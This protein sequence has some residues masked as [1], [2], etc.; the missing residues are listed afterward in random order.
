MEQYIKEILANDI[1]IEMKIALVEEELISGRPKK[2]SDS[3]NVVLLA[4]RLVKFGSSGES[5]LGWSIIKLFKQQHKE[6]LKAVLTIDVL[7]AI[8]Q[9]PSSLNDPGIAR[10]LE[11]LDVFLE[12]SPMANAEM[13]IEKSLVIYL[14][15]YNITKSDL[16]ST[17]DFY[18]KYPRCAPSGFSV[19]PFSEVLVKALAAFP[20]PQKSSLIADYSDE[21]K[22]FIEK[23]GNCLCQGQEKTVLIHALVKKVFIRIS[24]PDVCRNPSP[25]LAFILQLVPSDHIRS[26]VDKIIHECLNN[27]SPSGVVCVLCEWLIMSPKESQL[28][29]WIFGF[30]CSVAQRKNFEVIYDIAFASVKRLFSMLIIPVMRDSVLPVVVS[31]LIATRGTPDI[32]FLIVPQV[33]VFI[34]HLKQENTQGSKKT[35]KTI[36]E[37]ILMLMELHPNKVGYAK[38]NK[39]MQVLDEDSMPGPLTSTISPSNSTTSSSF[40]DKEPCFTRSN[41]VGL[42]NLNNTC[43]MNSILQALFMTKRF[44]DAILNKNEVQNSPTLEALQVLFAL[45]LHCERPSLSPDTILKLTRPSHFQKGRQQ[46]SYEYM[47]TLFD[48]IEREE[49]FIRNARSSEQVPQA[50]DLRK[51]I[52]S[53][54]SSEENSAKIITCSEQSLNFVALPNEESSTS[55]HKEK[56][57]NEKESKDV[58][59]GIV[60]SGEDHV[61]GNTP[62][63]FLGRICTTYKCLK[64]QSHSSH[65]DLFTDLQLCFPDSIMENKE[66]VSIQNLLDLYLQPE[67]LKGDNLYD[68][69]KCEGLQEGLKS[70]EISCSPSHLIIILKVFAYDSVTRTRKK[71]LPNVQCSRTIHLHASDSNNITAEEYQLYAIV[72]HKGG[73]IDA[74]HY[75]TFAQDETGMWS[76]FNDEVV[77]QTSFEDVLDKSCSHTPYLLFYQKIT[78]KLQVEVNQSSITDLQPHLMEMIRAENLRYRNEIQSKRKSSSRRLFQRDKDDFDPPS[79][80]GGGLGLGQTSSHCVF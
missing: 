33:P 23:L 2:F 36:M 63:I 34:H 9:R 20:M 18:T 64:C 31:L 41:R 13:E 69:T 55:A 68:C 39:A 71:L 47:M 65:K 48:V 59:N 66:P 58:A 57:G 17:L 6:R 46:D 10:L 72:A 67:D 51:T 21:M 54:S 43:Y 50:I 49:N 14:S 44:C 38:I 32:F 19:D 74:G 77:K 61:P 15:E 70:I 76:V 3:A 80:C 30:M 40:I 11:L 22:N 1:P 16:D 42:A 7:L 60:L 79:S 35:L 53:C 78:E 26:S 25:A 4:I 56:T 12:V 37:T 5:L 8:F 29:E 52:A 27:Q 73:S 28:P 62:E 75:V 45:L 24:N